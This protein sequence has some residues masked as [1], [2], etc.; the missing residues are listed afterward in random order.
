MNRT[1]SELQERLAELGRHL[2]SNEEEVVQHISP[3]G[4]A[5]INRDAIKGISLEQ[6][7]ADITT[8]FGY[9]KQRR[10][11]V[12]GS[13]PQTAQ[14]V[15]SLMRRPPSTDEMAMLV[16]IPTPLVLAKIHQQMQLQKGDAF[17]DVVEELASNYRHHQLVNNAK[18]LSN[19]RGLPISLI[20]LAPTMPPTSANL[21]AANMAKFKADRIYMGPSPIA[22]WFDELADVAEQQD[23]QPR[24]VTESSLVSRSFSPPV[25]QPT[26]NGVLKK[27]NAARTPQ[28][29]SSFL[30]GTNLSD[31]RSI[32]TA[33]RRS[34]VSFS[35]EAF[36]EIVD[37]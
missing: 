7:M 18:I 5:K 17:E 27:P 16:D 29:P 14:D 26:L 20:K 36:T 4:I 15:L 9:M 19:L 35:S 21:T 11:E 6:T 25:G 31:D 24:V 32:T 1:A 37:I 2:D 12:E 10:Q 3:Q 28:N 22:V 30:G 33:S 23:D 13:L 34:S 8:A